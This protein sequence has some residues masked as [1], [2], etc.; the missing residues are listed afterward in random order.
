MKRLTIKFHESVEG[1]QSF[2]TTSWTQVASKTGNLRA[3]ANFIFL[4]LEY[5]GSAVN[6]AVGVRV[7]VN[8]VE[9]SF[10]YHT[11]TLAGQYRKFC[12]FGVITP[13]VDADYTISVEVRAISSSQTVNVQRIRLMVMQT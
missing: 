4:S 12:D 2:T 11:P 13:S 5:G 1:V 9:R 6:Q 3:V 8:G 10:D 7:L